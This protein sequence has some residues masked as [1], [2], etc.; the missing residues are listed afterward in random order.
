MRKLTIAILMSV[1]T[2]GTAQAQTSKD[3]RISGTVEKFDGQLVS[4]SPSQGITLVVRFDAGPGIS[5]MRK[6]RPIDIKTD[7]QVSVQTKAN[8]AGGLLA[9][10]II[11]YENGSEERAG[12]EVS[13]DS[14]QIVARVTDVAPGNDGNTLS[15]AYKD[16][17][18]KVTIAK[19][20]LVWIARPAS[21]DD[22]K[23]GAIITI[24]GTKETDGEIK[25]VRASIGPAGADNPPL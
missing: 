5:S 13:T 22:I 9:S 25:V 21:A 4:I 12:G 7:Q 16:G 19:E 3:V 1:A 11:V 17:E 18:R 10:Q 8:P 2:F 23:P 20:A 24:A 6:A 14:S 15:L